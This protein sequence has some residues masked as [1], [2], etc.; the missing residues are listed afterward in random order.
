MY[1]IDTHVFIWMLY[2]PEMLSDD[3]MALISDSDLAISIATL[4][5]MSIKKTKGQISFDETIPELAAICKRQGIDILPITPAH[6][7][8]IQALPLYHKD[9][10]DRIIMAQSLVE[11][12]PLVTR[13]A[14]IWNGYPEVHKVW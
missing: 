5:E 12:W 7:Q 3:A 14:N 6:C 10:F 2:H 4:W 13:D 1:L 8:R 11:G 9:P